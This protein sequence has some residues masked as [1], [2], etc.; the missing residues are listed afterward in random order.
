M[1]DIEIAKS[2][3]MKNIKEIAEKININEE[4]ILSK[5][6]IILNDW[7]LIL[8]KNKYVI[9]RYMIIKLILMIIILKG[10]IWNVLYNLIIIMDA[11]KK[12]KA[13]KRTVPV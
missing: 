12:I 6:T 2:A 5:R 4:Y 7:L 3:K 9:L 10:F 11:T 13:F 8:S 1:E